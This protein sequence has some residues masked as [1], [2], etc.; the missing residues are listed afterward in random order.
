MIVPKRIL[1]VSIGAA[2]LSLLSILPITSK[3]N[4]FTTLPIQLAALAETVQGYI[5]PPRR[6]RRTQRSDGSGSRGCSQT[7]P[8]SLTLLTPSDH[9]ATTVSGRPTFLWYISELTNAPMR[10]TLVEPGVSEPV[11]D[12][13]LK[14]DKPG[15][16]QMQLPSDAL[17]LVE[18]KEYRWTV[19]I[20]CNENRPSENVYARAWILRVPNTPSLV[21]KLTAVTGNQDSAMIYAQSGVWYDAIST[22][23]LDSLANPSDQLSSVYFHELLDQ[24]GLSKVVGRDRERNLERVGAKAR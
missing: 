24:V 4:T 7:T 3:I 10:F 20:V 6:I 9:V 16:V 8:V 14:V 13:Q 17:E 19:S 12:K 5:P 22:I 23:Y 18:G 2:S 21:Q 1:A 11:V 15:I